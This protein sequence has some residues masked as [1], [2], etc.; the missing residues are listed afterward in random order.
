VEVEE[1][2]DSSEETEK[3]ARKVDTVEAEVTEADI[4]VAVEEVAQEAEAVDKVSQDQKVRPL[5]V[6]KLLV[7]RK[8]KKTTP[9]F[10]NPTNSK[11]SPE[12][13][14]THMIENQALAEAVFHLKE[15]MEEVA[16]VRLKTKSREKK[17]KKR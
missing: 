4:A 5:K 16:G 6:K 12:R 15:D 14:G 2:T 9:I 7:P 1:G 10:T 13:T 3:K 17:K 11:V 8:E